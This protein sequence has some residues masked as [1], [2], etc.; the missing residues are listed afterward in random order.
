M[1]HPSP[2]CA[3]V[4]KNGERCKN[5]AMQDSEFCRVHSGATVPPPVAAPAAAPSAASSPEGPSRA[6]VEAMAS[7]FNKLADEMSKKAPDFKPPPYSPASLVSVLKANL[8]Q[9]AAC[10][11]VDLLRDIIRNLEGTKKEDLLDPETWKGFWYIL[12]YSLTTQSKSA[13]EELAK[14]LSIIPGMDLVVQ[15]TQS[16]L[17]SP[18]D[19]LSIDTW[20]GAALI[21]N[22]AVQANASSVKRKVMGESEE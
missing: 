19:L 9:L 8:D 5:R 1:E 3:A 14:R 2:Q 6:Q 7:E 20:K 18:R 22:A 4:K 16:V 12:T 21:L 11:P 10:L 17:E 13:L 15:F